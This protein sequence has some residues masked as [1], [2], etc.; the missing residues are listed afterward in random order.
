MARRW[1]MRPGGQVESLDPEI[2]LLSADDPDMPTPI[3]P[4]I[5]TLTADG[6]LRPANLLEQIEEFDR[7]AG[8][9]HSIMLRIERPAEPA[10][11]L[12][13]E[14]L[15]RTWNRPIVLEEPPELADM[16]G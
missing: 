13:I 7:R 8:R 4:V 5:G 1:L 6:L 15:A 2:D 10:D 9:R 11:F 14:R 3:G 12:R 16:P